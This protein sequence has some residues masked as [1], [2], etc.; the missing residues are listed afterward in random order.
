MPRTIVI[1][2]GALGGPTAAARA[3][4][5]DEDA[6]IILLERNIRVSYAQCAL[7]AHLSGEV[8]SLDDLNREREE[9]FRDVY[10]IEVRLRTEA[11][12][13]QAKDRR[14]S[15][16]SA[17]GE[18]ELGYDSL[19]FATGV[20]SQAAPGLAGLAN[21]AFFRTLDDLQRI[22]TALNSGLRRFVIFGG[23]A[24][25][26]EAADG[27]IRAG[28]QV[29]IIEK[30][31]QLLP[32]FDEDFAALARRSLAAAA[33]IRTGIDSVQPQ[34]V[35]NA[36]Q[37]IVCNGERI[38][39]DF[40]L[41]C[42]G[43]TPR[44]DLLAAAG[45][46]LHA[47]RSIAVDE[48]CQT[49]LSDIYACG[50]GIGLPDGSGG[51]SMRPQAAIA[52]RS[53]QVA[54]ANA[55][56]GA[57]RL[58]SMAASLLLRLPETEI[59]GC[60]LSLRQ[61]RV[62]GKNASR[63]VVHVLDRESYMPGAKPATLSLIF[64]RIDASILGLEAIGP[65]LSRYLDAASLAVAAKMSVTELAGLDNAYHPTSGAAR[66]ALFVAATVASQIVSGHGNVIEAAEIEEDRERF[67]IL[68]VG[69]APS[70]RS[71]LHIPLE[72]LRHRITEVQSAM[73][74][75]GAKSVLTL[76]ETGR[77]AH[78]AARI[79]SQRGVEAT[80]IQGGGR[81]AFGVD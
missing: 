31:E 47:D 44:S 74:R 18:E 54:G 21:H 64:D 73:Q 37:S 66:D 1:I 5:Y 11:T 46:A 71:D 70:P 17:A 26:V 58:Q 33:Q 8:Q 57:Q 41:S 51:F 67:L 76:S 69:R 14:V 81:F 49:T 4:E 7:S 16:R 72:E 53:A 35:D 2:G 29:T 40:V 22:K 59:G 10:N 80:T 55:A 43:V 19:I 13:I 62:A 65:G 9:F 45:A 68:N 77:R 56:G 12:A 27:L 28:A 20:E 23:G 24:L 60:G 36:L 6:R 38:P 15:L 78:L 39:C 30:E 75:N 34:I 63:A 79:L 48:R 3:R 32:Q 42:V 50:V 25:G 52:D 61:A